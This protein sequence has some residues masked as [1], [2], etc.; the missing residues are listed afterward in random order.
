MRVARRTIVTKGMEQH[1]HVVSRVVDRRKIFGEA[2]KEYF[3]RLMRKQEGFSGIQVLGYCLMGNHFHLLLRVPVPP[4]SLDDE[5]VM[6]RLRYIYSGEQIDQIR[7]QLEV[8]RQEGNH[9]Q[10]EGFFERAR[11]RMYDLSDFVKDLKQRFSTWYNQVTERKGTL[12]EER[13]RSVLVEGSGQAL[14]RVLAYID[15]NPVRA[16]IV[17]TAASYSWSSFSE[18]VKGSE[19]AR[20]GLMYVTA[21]AGLTPDK[22]QSD[23]RTQYKKYSDYLS[24]KLSSNNFSEKY[25]D[26]DEQEST[27]MHESGVTDHLLAKQR[28][29]I[30]GLILGS[31]KFIQEHYDTKKGYLCQSRKYLCWPVPGEDCTGLHTYRKIH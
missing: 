29:L 16:G 18:A 12:W 8:W 5:E 15:L 4:S 20:N 21:A 30:E 26:K 17:E 3:Y 6:R 10:I 13:F 1:F 2:E 31:H 25:P 19:K 14:M 27:L 24:R 7:L 28:Y 11:A 22:S 9:T 23:W